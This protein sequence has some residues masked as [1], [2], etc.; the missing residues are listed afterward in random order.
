[1]NRPPKDYDVATSATPDLLAAGEEGEDLVGGGGGGDVVVL[2]GAV[3]E[4]VADAAAGE[5]GDVAGG[6]EALDDAAGEGFGGREH[7]GIVRGERG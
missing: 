6:L 4:L 7:E 1:M 2:W 5:V 3:H